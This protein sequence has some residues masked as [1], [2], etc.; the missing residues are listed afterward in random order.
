MQTLALSDLFF[1]KVIQE[2]PLGG[3]L[4]P[5]PLGKGRVNAAWHSDFLIPWQLSYRRAKSLEK[6]FL[7]LLK[8]NFVAFIEISG[9]RCANTNLH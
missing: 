5:P 7:R 4:D 9:N 3:R 2:K 1:S 8:C 6:C